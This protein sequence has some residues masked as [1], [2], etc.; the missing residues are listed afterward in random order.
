MKP[1]QPQP[2]KESK[3]PGQPGKLRLPLEISLPVALGILVVLLTVMYAFNKDWRPTI[4]F[5]GTATAV[6]AGISSAYYVALKVRATVEQLRITVEQR[7]RAIK[8]Q[9]VS[10]A[11]DFL[12]RWNDPNFATLRAEW[13][14]LLREVDGKT[15]DEI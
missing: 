10:L 3:L 8:D 13:R 1:E 15:P 2:S 5:F 12:R 4:T 7:D 9:K 14:K 11:L 6:A